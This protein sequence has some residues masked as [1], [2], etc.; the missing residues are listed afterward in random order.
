[1]NGF[2]PVS[3]TVLCF[4][5]GCWLER[6]LAAATPGAQAGFA[7]LTALTLLALLEHWFMVLPLPDQKLWRWMI[8]PPAPKTKAPTRAGLKENPNGL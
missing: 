8:D 4:A 5:A 2:F 3:V 1:M 7:L 6:L